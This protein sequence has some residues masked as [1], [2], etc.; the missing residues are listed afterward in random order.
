[1][2]KTLAPQRKEWLDALRGLAIILVVLLHNMPAG[3]EK[4]IYIILTGPIKLP[5]FFAI[6]GYVFNHRDGHQ[7]K[8]FLNL[9][10]KIFLPS[11]VLFFCLRAVFIPTRGIEY[12]IDGLIDFFRGDVCWYIS[13][14]IIGEILF[15]YILKFCKKE[16]Q[17]ILMALLCWVAGF[18]MDHFEIGDFAMIN[19]AFVAQYFLLLGYLFRKHEDFFKKLHWSFLLLGFL[20]TAGM[21]GLNFWLWPDRG[22][23]VHN[24][25]Y[26]GTLSAIPFCFALITVFTLSLMTLGT[27][28]GRLSRVLAIVG[29][30]T[31]VTY[32]YHGFFLSIGMRVLKHGTSTGWVLV[33][34]CLLLTAFSVTVCTLGS[35]LINWLLPELMGRKRKKKEKKT[36]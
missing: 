7:G 28:L 33:G 36:V 13:A 27:K 25:F 16:W 21:I 9:F 34:K 32:I 1:M 31:L 23:D 22:I 3:D 2:G 8:F 18:V 15:F 24:N 6:S 10:R 19:R 30:H 26:H 12:V 4:N 14:C 29:R 11:L 5:L 20:I 35:M 17:I